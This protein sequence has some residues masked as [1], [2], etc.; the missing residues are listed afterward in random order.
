MGSTLVYP[1]YFICN[2]EFRYNVSCLAQQRGLPQLPLLENIMRFL[3]LVVLLPTSV[4]AVEL[5]DAELFTV[6]KSYKVGDL[7]QNLFKVSRKENDLVM[8]RPHMRIVIRY[9]ESNDLCEYKARLFEEIRGLSRKVDENKITIP[10]LGRR[11]KLKSYNGEKFMV[12]FTSHDYNKSLPDVF[13]LDPAPQG[14]AFNWMTHRIAYYFLNVPEK[15]AFS[16]RVHADAEKYPVEE[17][18]K[19]GNAILDTLKMK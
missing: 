5:Y 2:S 7:S 9:D 18:Q 19:I 14:A 10:M 3:F 12:E 4:V 15:G 6:A 1:F 16:I 8:E 11:T 17:H 13:I